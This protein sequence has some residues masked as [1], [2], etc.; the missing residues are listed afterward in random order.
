M[1]YRHRVL[2]LLI[3]LF[4]IV[5]LDRVCISVAAPYTGRLAH[6]SHWLE[7]GDGDVH[8]PMSSYTRHC[9]WFPRPLPRTVRQTPSAEETITRCIRY[10]RGSSRTLCMERISCDSGSPSHFIRSS[11]CPASISDK[12]TR[13]DSLR[14]FRSWIATLSKIFESC[15]TML[16]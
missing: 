15:Y 3:L 12:D 7:L 2:G 16:P 9:R 6:R 4:A 10:K 13:A 1:K 11:W 5:Y 14:I 8:A